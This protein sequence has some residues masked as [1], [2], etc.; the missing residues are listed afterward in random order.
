MVAADAGAISHF[1][2]LDIFAPDLGNSEPRAIIAD[3]LARRVP[4]RGR[5]IL[6]CRASLPIIYHENIVEPKSGLAYPVVLRA[7]QRLRQ[8]CPQSA[9]PHP[10]KSVGALSRVSPVLPTRERRPQGCAMLHGS[11]SSGRP[12][13]LSGR[14]ARSRSEGYARGA[15]EA[16][17]FRLAIAGTFQREQALDWINTAIDDGRAELEAQH[18]LEREIDAWDMSCRI[19]FMVQ[20]TA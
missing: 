11:R 12:D 17:L 10:Q 5:N 19:M 16:K 18:S 7:T 9:S 2:R 6:L 4:R 8:P 13:T 14:M 15:H 1:G 3:R 20:I